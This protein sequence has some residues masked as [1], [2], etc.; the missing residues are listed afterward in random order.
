MTHRPTVHCVNVAQF[1]FAQFCIWSYCLHDDDEVVI[2]VGIVSYE[3][4]R[5][6]DLQSRT[7]SSV[8]DSSIPEGR[9]DIALPHVA[10]LVVVVFDV[11]SFINSPS[12]HDGVVFVVA[13]SFCSVS[14]PVLWQSLQAELKIDAR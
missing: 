10:W 9:N 6:L 2:A 11:F 14:S 13:L 5:P 4:N 3:D 8:V 1:V 7:S 12:L